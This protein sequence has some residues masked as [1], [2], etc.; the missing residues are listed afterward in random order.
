MKDIYLFVRGPGVL[1]SFIVFLVGTMYQIIWFFK[2]TKRY[3]CGGV[4][5]FIPKQA[6]E[7]IGP[8]IEIKKLAKREG[9][10]WS[11]DPF[12]VV[13]T[14]L[15]HF[16]V[17]ITPLFLLAHNLL[18]KESWSISLPSFSE[19]LSDMCTLIILGFGIYFLYR[20]IFN[21]KVR[22]ITSFSDYWTFILVFLPYLTGFL[23]YHQIF[24]YSYMVILHII[25]GELMI[26]L[27]PFSKLRHL[28]FFFLN[29]IFIQSEYSFFKKGNRVWS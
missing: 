14:S 23:A 28:I 9:T 8:S 19:K 2:N 6:L 26:M 13:I 24:P 3:E 27:I 7:N 21:R 17:I 5:I 1:I 12:F 22:S 11:T 29:R 10:A 16:F 25:S 18:L 20:R 15:F 4:P